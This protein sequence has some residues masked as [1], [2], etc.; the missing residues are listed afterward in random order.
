MLWTN[1]RS[2][3]YASRRHILSR[4]MFAVFLVFGAFDA[5]VF[6]PKWK[7]VLSHWLREVTGRYS[8]NAVPNILATGIVAFYLSSL[9]CAVC[10]MHIN[11][12]AAFPFSLTFNFW[13]PKILLHFSAT[14]FIHHHREK[15]N[16]SVVD[17]RRDREKWRRHIF[18]WW[19]NTCSSHS[20]NQ[21]QLPYKSV[22]WE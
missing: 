1:L 3:Y 12:F 11:L 20:M 9:T 14:S 15:S 21:H 13:N 10:T 8:T 2:V 4:A 7:I 16:P 6:C 22:K 5:L 17:A 18:D 19:S